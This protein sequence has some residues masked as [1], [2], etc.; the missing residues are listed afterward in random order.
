MSDNQ[1]ILFSSIIILGIVGLI[2]GII[3]SHRRKKRNRTSETDEILMST[4][5]IAIISMLVIT[6]FLVVIVAVGRV[7]GFHLGDDEADT[8][9]GEKVEVVE[10]DRLESAVEVEEGTEEDI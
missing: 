5:S 8:N 2:V 6:I 9:N 10:N 3:L 7:T 4:N 1:V